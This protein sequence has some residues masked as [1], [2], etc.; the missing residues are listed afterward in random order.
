MQSGCVQICTADLTLLAHT[1]EHPD[2]EQG[3]TTGV[4]G[5]SFHLY[6]ALF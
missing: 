1:R 4:K 6:D 3:I 2:K 5:L